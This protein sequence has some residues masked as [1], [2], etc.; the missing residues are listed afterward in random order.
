MPAKILTFYSEMGGGGKTT[1]VINVAAALQAQ[2]KRCLVVDLDSQ[3][4]ASKWL[5]LDKDDLNQPNTITAFEV[6]TMQNMA[7]E[8]IMPVRDSLDLIA[9]VDRLKAADRITAAE[10]GREFFVKQQLA[11]VRDRY[12]YILIDPPGKSGFLSTASM[13]AA[14]YVI[15]PI[16]ANKKGYDAIAATLPDIVL[17]K[18]RLNA[19]LS[20]LGILLVRF[21]G[22][23]NISFDIQDAVNEVYGES[24][25]VFSTVIHEA[26][27]LQY[28]F[29]HSQTILEYDAKSRAAKEYVAFAKE[30]EI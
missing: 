7:A 8:A 1:S 4:D 3:A 6:V 12:D 14:D 19:A 17:I 22:A 24:I 16:E 29:A 26:K 15:I 18:Q 27:A 9:G 28:A 20:I 30:L 13:A 25:G 10:I 5:G 11:E 2:G 23:S 21:H